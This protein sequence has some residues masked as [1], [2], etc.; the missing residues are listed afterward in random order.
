M[1]IKKIAAALAVLMLLIAVLP[2]GAFAD[3]ESSQTE[4]SPG[5]TSGNAVIA[6]CLDDDQYLYLDRADETVAPAVATKLVA[7]MVFYD[8]MQEKGLPIATTEVTVTSTAID[9]SGD[10][11]DV[12]VPMMG[13][14]AGS[15]YTAKDLISATLVAC[16]NDACAALACYGGEL[17]GGNII[18]FIER[19][20]KKA[21]S[22]GLQNTRF[23]NPTGLDSPNQAS[24]PREVA[25]IATAF[26]KYNDLVTL[27]NV[28]SFYFNN[29]SL[30][31]NKNYLLSNYY[32]SGYIN[33]N[34]I[35]LIAGQKDKNGDYCLISASQKDGRTYIFVVM[36][37][38]GMLVDAERHYSF[39]SGNAYDDMNKLIS[40]TRESFVF[41]EIASTVKVIDEL[42][43][44]AG[45]SSDHVLIVPAENVESL[46]NKALADSIE[47]TITY[48]TDKVY[49]SEV[50]GVSYNTV[51]A[52]VERGDIFGTVTYYCN[53]IEL[54]TV[55]AAAK[56]SVATN[57]LQTAYTGI[58]EFLFSDTMLTVLKVIGV[59]IIVYVIV[60]LTMAAIRASR[61]VKKNPGSSQK[62]KK[63][64]KSRNK[65]KKSLKDEMSDTKEL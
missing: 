2:F 56:E 38:T 34:A 30:V 62:P 3:D 45:D 25:M 44:E 9:N 55:G 35:G 46:V 29:K 6:Y 1:K 20:N 27:S 53:G 49:Q 24:T 18:T 10:I 19:M 23:V 36:C 15:V 33:K 50:N 41:V 5:I 11:S 7:M 17:L 54:A 31:R 43:V 51:K 12:R 64:I 61:R 52:P 39:E 14:K 21:E 8:I 60:A 59:I 13:L 28:E 47:F 57:E 58:K 16:A 48:D 63:E 32:V 65:A 22:L 4:A 26:Y 42:R 40:W 37:A